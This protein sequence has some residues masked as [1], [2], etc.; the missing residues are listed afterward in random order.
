MTPNNSWVDRFVL[1]V[2]D[3]EIRARVRVDAVP[4]LDLAS[5]PV[6]AAVPRLQKALDA[7]FVPTTQ[8]CN[9]LRYLIGVAHS[10]AQDRYPD[11]GAFLRAAYQERN[12]PALL[13]P[14]CITSLG[15]V[16]KS[17]LAAALSRI[18]PAPSQ[19]DVPLHGSV[20][21]VSHWHM[22]VRAGSTT[23]ALLRPFLRDNTRNVHDAASHQLYLQGVCLIILDELQF[24]SQSSDANTAVAKTLMQMSIL[25]P[26]L[27]FVANFSL[28]HRLLRRP[29]E[30]RQRLLANPYFLEPDERGS[31]DWNSCLREKFRVAPE[32]EQLDPR[33]HGDVI[34][35]YT[36][37]I[38]RLVTLLLSMAYRICR[39][40]RSKFVNDDH[41]QQAYRSIEYSIARRD[42][43]LLVEQTISGKMVRDGSRKRTDLWCPLSSCAVTRAIA[44]HPAKTE[45]DRR[46][47]EAH[48]AAGLSAEAREAYR[49]LQRSDKSTAPETGNV[50]KLRRPPATREALLEGAAE[51][52]QTLDDKS[53]EPGPK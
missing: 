2:S 29:Q 30:E 44:Q 51:F 17:E 9:A 12:L 38:K 15:G 34:H 8:V 21:L 24:L 32:L 27:V 39:N 53:L 18:L 16:G 14:I 43:E 36:F 46:V 20:P 4:I 7:V 41:I 50:V 3:E 1:T 11:C 13:R 37:G 31:D 5:Y 48:V 33:K 26:H 42:V 45:Y 6:E 40:T 49:S 10:C 47:A 19:V 35:N 52:Y 28:L 25:G 22:V 23:S